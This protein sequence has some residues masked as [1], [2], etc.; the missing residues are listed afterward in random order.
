MLT[1]YDIL[2]I[3]GF[4][5]AALV[6]L[7]VVKYRADET[8]TVVVQVDGAEVIRLPLAV[9]RRFSVDGRLGRTDMEIKDGRVRVLNSPCRRKTCVHAGWIYKPYQ[10]IICMPNRVVIRLTGGGDKLD[11]ITG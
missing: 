6:G 8:D 4:L 3:A 11:G 5:I 10:T 2:L 7:G 9:D 1:R